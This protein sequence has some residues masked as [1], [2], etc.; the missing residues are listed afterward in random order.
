MNDVCSFTL[1]DLDKGACALLVID[2]C[3]PEESLNDAQRAMVDA[4][5]QL[6]AAARAA[7]V[8]V[9]FACDA[10]VEG[11]DR[12]LLLWG[13]HGMANTPAALPTPR[14]GYCET[15][16][17][18]PKRRYSAFFQTGLRL[19]LDELGTSTLIVAGFDTNICVRH[20]LADAFFNNY[21]TVVVTDATCTFLVGTQEQG[22]VEIQKCYGSLLAQSSEV[23][24]FLS[25]VTD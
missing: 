6:C 19:L 5:E 21:D 16:Y 18:V 1:S 8:P 2:E 24:A 7:E 4:T 9:I 25:S 23:V 22:L 14:L 13:E 11:I 12:E 10:H 20:T 15:E 17:L 3:G